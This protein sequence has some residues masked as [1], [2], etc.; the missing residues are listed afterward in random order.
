MT[1]LNNTL[2]QHIIKRINE[3]QYDE[4]IK[5]LHYTFFESH[6]I[7]K[8]D[9]NISVALINIPCGGFG[10]IVNCK[11]FSDYLKEWYPSMK[12]YICTSAPDKFKSLGIPTKDLIKLVPIKVYKKEEGGECQPFNN[13][14]FSKKPP[15][16][17][18]TIVVPMVNEEFKYYNVQE[19]YRLFLLPA[20][21]LIGLEMIL[22]FT[23]F[24]SFI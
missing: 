11:T 18:I 9:Y 7:T 16:F 13:L 10:D 21:M 15:N 22:K 6:K 3:L 14:K 23:L 17:D 2:Y 20:L 8:K 19:K 12:V 5:I 4:D 1:Q 24:R